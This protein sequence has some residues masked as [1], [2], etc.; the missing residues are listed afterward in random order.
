MFLWTASLLFAAFAFHI[1]NQRYSLTTRAAEYILSATERRGERNLAWVRNAALF[2]LA[3]PFE[4]AFHPV[5][6]SLRWL[7]ESP[8][9]H[10]TPAERVKMLKELMPEAVEETEILLREYHAS[11]YSRRGGDIRIARRASLRLL[12]LGLNAAIR[13]AQINSRW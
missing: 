7:G 11:Q 2:V 12:W 9:T 3:D 1:M 8:A 5:N 10:L 6:L 4:R 13:R